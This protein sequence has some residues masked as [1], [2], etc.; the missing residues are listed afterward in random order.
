MACI[1][2]AKR[3]L[4]AWHQATLPTSASWPCSPADTGHACRRSALC[5]SLRHQLGFNHIIAESSARIEQ[6]GGYAAGTMEAYFLLAAAHREKS[7]EQSN[8]SNAS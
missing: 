8:V 5:F 1:H 2:G 4:P 6:Y 3:T 7:I